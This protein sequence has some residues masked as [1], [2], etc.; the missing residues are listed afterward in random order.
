M[1]DMNELVREIG[2]TKRLLTKAVEDQDK[3]LSTFG[4]V[5][6]KTAAAVEENHKQLVKLAAEFKQV[7][8]RLNDLDK[9]AGRAMLHGL[10]VHGPAHKTIGQQVGA[11]PDVAALHGKAIPKGIKLNIPVS[12]QMRKAL[13]AFLVFNDG[14]ANGADGAAATQTAYVPGIADRPF[15]SMRIRDL[16]NVA[17]CSTDS[18]QYIREKGFYNLHTTSTASAASGQKNISV[19]N[20]RG[21]FSGQVIQIRGATPEAAVVDT[22]NYTTNVITVVANLAN[23]AASGS[24]V[25]SDVFSGSP[26][27]TLKPNLK[28][29]LENVVANVITVAH[30]V[31][32]SKQILADVPRLQAFLDGKLMGGLM[33]AEDFQILY[34]GGGAD[35]LPG[36][37][38]QAAGSFAW[39]AMPVGSTMVDAIRRAKRIVRQSNYEA[40]GVILNPADWETIETAK[41]SD[42]HYLYTVRATPMGPV[43][44]GV[45]V[46][47][48][49]AMQAGD[50]LVGAFGLAAQLHDRENGSVNIYDQHEDYAARNLLYMLAEERLA[51]E[52]SRPAGLCKID[53]DAAPAA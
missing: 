9:K 51:L 7:E 36:L 15:E 52:I 44:W 33:T 26:E 20:A 49:N 34:G 11:H 28:V 2:E 13:P 38:G 6:E 30:G 50:C 18:V 35:Q 31:T 32:A 22:V 40:T 25:V 23:T 48:T 24:D 53:F 8:D 14:T 5:S 39:S 21:F 27:G 1:A 46:V 19:V 37:M 3:Q 17:P 47:E 41:G 4:K 10:P 16:L 42:G 29:Q 45:N 43:L 12:G